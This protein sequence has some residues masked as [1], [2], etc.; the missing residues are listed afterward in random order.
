MSWL[1]QLTEC[2]YAVVQRTECVYPHY[3]VSSR[4][5]RLVHCGRVKLGS[6]YDAQLRDASCRV[7][8]AVSLDFESILVTRQC[9]HRT[10]CRVARIDSKSKL[11]ANPTRHDA[12]CR[13]AYLSGILWTSLYAFGALVCFF[14][15]ISTKK[16][17]TSSRLLWPEL[18]AVVLIVC[19]SKC[20]VHF[21]FLCYDS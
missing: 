10:R 16:I 11:A 17:Y 5:M 13:V 21:Q 9:A 19:F 3:P 1:V 2:V 7:G 6:Q 18:A 12:F 20:F 8:F 14:L 15:C 4:V